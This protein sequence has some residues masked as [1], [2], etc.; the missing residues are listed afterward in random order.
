MNRMISFI[1]EA[2]HEFHERYKIYRQYGSIRN[3]ISQPNPFTGTRRDR[4]ADAES[5]PADASRDLSAETA[6]IKELRSFGKNLFDRPPRIVFISYS[7]PCPESTSSEFRLFQII[8]ILLKNSCDIM[9]LFCDPHSINSKHQQLFQGN[10]EFVYVP[11]DPDYCRELL[12]GLKHDYIWVTELWRLNYLQFIAALCEKVSHS[13]L[14]SKLIIDTVDFHFKEFKRKYDLT[15]DP[16]DLQLADDFLA[17]ENVLYR[18]ADIVLCISR[19][20]KNDIQR[21]IHGIKQIEILPNIHE[22]PDTVRPYE[23]RKHICFVGHFGNKH[24]TDAVEYFIENIFPSISAKHPGIEFHI[25]GYLSDIQCRRFESGQVKVIG[26]FKYLDV[27]L[28]YYRLFVCP[29]TYGAGMKGKI[30]SAISAGV[31]VVTTSLG[32]EGFP[33]RDGEECFITDSPSEFSAKCNICLSEADV[34]RRLSVK[35]RR[36]M[37]ENFSPGVISQHISQIFS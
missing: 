20:E 32:A 14:D 15:H 3:L 27:A 34:W 37:A 36:M 10:I 16:N 11:M 17:I 23:E 28:S 30:G 4:T 6:R 12:S 31:P 5:S 35:S 33:F 21:M 1:R 7:I 29:L 19:E 25:L 24:N 13:G 8:N 2:K 22:V 9:F 26:G 18:K